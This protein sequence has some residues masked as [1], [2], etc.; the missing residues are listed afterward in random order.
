MVDTPISQ[1]TPFTPLGRMV[2]PVADPALGNGLKNGSV[3]LDEI[4]S[5]VAPAVP[6]SLSLNG[7]TLIGDSRQNFQT[8]PVG[9]QN[10]FHYFN[11]ANAQNGQRYQLVNMLG[12][13]GNRSDQYLAAGAATA[14][15]DSSKYV[16]IWSIINDLDFGV[17]AAQAWF[18]GSYT[19]SS[20]FIT[21][22]G[23]LPFCQSLIAA[24]KIPVLISEIGVGGGGAGI[25]TGCSQY[26]EYCREFA[27]SGKAIY[28][29]VT[30][31]LW[32]PAAASPTNI[33]LIAARMQDTLHPNTL[34]SFYM[35]PLFIAALP[36]IPPL[37][38]QPVAASEDP[39]YQLL[40]NN[41]FTTTTGGTSSGGTLTGNIPANWGLTI[42]A[43]WT[44]A[45]STGANAN[46]YGNNLILQVT[47]TGLGQLSLDQVNYTGAVPGG[48]Y[49]AGLS[50]SVTS[51][52]ANFVGIDTAVQSVTAGGTVETVDYSYGGNAEVGPSSAPYSYV[53]KTPK[54]RLSPGAVSYVFFLANATFVAAGTATIVISQAYLRRRFS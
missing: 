22:M 50:V 45:A 14:L 28:I 40:A 10:S 6:A 27:E 44:V 41:L 24:G 39:N 17:T 21:N 30:P 46:G 9:T 25:V 3:T 38:V 32:N 5:F 51:P 48:I 34:G 2:V 37:N 15:S 33:A 11:Q 43:G 12:I 54:N 29:D 35:A 7:F 23:I 18:G 4:A 53:T 20:T 49:E 8:Q 19:A 1:M 47:A 13:A 36:N 16:V 42:P 52:N 26:N 31:V